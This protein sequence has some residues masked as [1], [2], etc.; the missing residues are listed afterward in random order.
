MSAAAVAVPARSAIFLL[1]QNRLLREALSRVLEKKQDLAIVG[2][3]AL[4]PFSLEEIVKAAPDILVMDS[5][6]TAGPNREFVREAQ[7]EVAQLKV[8]MIGME[9]DE[10]TFMYVLRQGALG[11]VLKD[12]SAFEVVTTVRAVANG[13]A[14]CPPQL[15]ALLFRY[16]TRQL[17]QIPSF[18]VK[19][20]LGFTSREQQLIRLIG[21]GL[22][23]KEIANELQLA[24]QTVRNHVHRMLR[25]AGAS[26]RLAVVEICRMQGLP[27]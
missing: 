8:V 25:K 9:E 3:C 27:V 19:T 12:A 23:N 16:A 6:V 13:E 11:Y 26:D 22:T 5:I 15:S 21:L 18:H 7:R 17:N 2:A 14:V 4:S 24:E 1:A 10:Q 20:C